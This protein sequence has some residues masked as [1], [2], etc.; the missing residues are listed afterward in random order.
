MEAYSV[1]YQFVRGP[2][3]VVAVVVFLGGFIYQVRGLLVA[4]KKDGAFRPYYNRRFAL[5]SIYYWLIPY[6]TMS[7]RAQPFTTLASFLFH[8]SLFLIPIFLLA[9]NLLWYE[10]LGISW[11][12]L[13]EKVADV[14]TVIFLVAWLVLLLRRVA[15]PLP[16]FVTTVFDYLLLLGVLLP[17]LTGFL[18][19][20]QWLLPYKLTVILHILSA[21]VI[22]MALPFTRLMHMAYFFFTRAFMGSEFGFR[23]TRDW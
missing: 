3:F 23:G 10:S 16:H 12:T 4:F 17:F 8:L 9:H 20:H 19:S 5:R 2:L 6:G 15:K 11:W 14:I 21:E 18:A 7:M 1:L 13:P 22:L